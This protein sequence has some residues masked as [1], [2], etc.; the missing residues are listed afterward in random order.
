[1]K[2]YAAKLVKKG[3]SAKVFLVFFTVFRVGMLNFNDHACRWVAS[4]LNKNHGISRN[5]LLAAYKTKVLGGSGLDADV[6]GGGAYNL[7]QALLHQRYVGIH[8]RPLGAD[9]G[10]EVDEAIAFG[11]N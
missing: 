4:A 6:V 10:I 8:L 7:C 1:M 5:A 2:K 9:G 11:G 3:R